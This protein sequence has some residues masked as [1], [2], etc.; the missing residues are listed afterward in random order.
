MKLASEEREERP[1]QKAMRV[2]APEPVTVPE[3]IQVARM[4]KQPAERVMPWAKVLV[5][6]PVMSSA[7][8]ALIPPLKVE[9]ELLPPETLIGAPLKVEVAAPAKTAARL[10]ESVL[11]VALVGALIIARPGEER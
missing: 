8:V 9:V 11:L 6:L 3:P 7:R 1:F 4:A 5:A 10:T 2:L